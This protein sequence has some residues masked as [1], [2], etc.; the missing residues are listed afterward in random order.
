MIKSTGV[1]KTYALEVLGCK[2]NR[3]DASQ[4][5]R[6]LEGYGFRPVAEDGCAGLVVLHTCGVTSTAVGKCRRTL[7]RLG[8]AHPEA[9]VFISGCAASVTEADEDGHV[10]RIPAGPGWIASFASHLDRIATPCPGFQLPENDDE[11]PARTDCEQTRLYLKIQDGCDRFCSYCIVP[12]LRKGPRDKPEEQVVA[13]AVEAVRRGCRE[14][15][16]TGV[17][18]GLYGRDAGGSLAQ[19]LARVV[20]QTGPARIRLGSLHPAEVTGELLAVWAASPR[21]MPHV[22]LSLQSGS[23]SVLGRM[24][25]GYTTQ[26]FRGAVERA[27]A[28][29]HR[30]GDPV[31]PSITTDVI[32]GFPGETDD[33]F[34]QTMDFCR[35]IG[36]A[37][38]HVFPFSARPGTR[39]AT[40]GDPV[41]PKTIHSRSRQLG[42]LAQELRAAWSA[43]WSGHPVEVLVEQC[44][45][46]WCTGQTGHYIPARIKGDRSM[47]GRLVK[48]VFPIS[49]T[50]QVPESKLP[51]NRGC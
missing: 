11:L 18:L 48:T 15:V 23:D 4:I 45:N 1:V 46:G 19:V 13:E 10:I 6:L 34:G 44:E 32:V 41:D 5:C 12:L 17:H 26:E 40:M 30:D 35:C 42:R 37:D 7:S 49:G 33:E 51:G 38:M 3:Y 47:I 50:G 27:R 20:E 16:L 21:V 8:R 22:H 29:L 25:R 2:V 24:R 31:G 36:F 28:A 39:A 43:R 14:I 9:L